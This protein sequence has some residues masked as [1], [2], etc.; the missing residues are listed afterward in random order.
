[1][2]SNINANNIDGTYP[3]AGVDNDSQGFRTNFTNIKNN[4]AYAKS[5]LEDLQTKAI[6]KSALTGS[7]LSND[8]AGAVLSNAEIKGFRETEVDLGT[9]SGTV[10]LDHSAGHFH[11]ITTNGSITL[12]FSNFPTTGKVG[13][14]RFKI[15]VASTAHT[16]TLPSAVGA[17][18]SAT[19][20][21]GIQGW[22][23]NIITF[24]ATGTYIYEFITDTQGTYIY[25]QDLTSSRT[26]ISGT[27]DSTSSTTG[28]F[29]VAGGIGIAGNT[30]IGGNL[31][32][33]GDIIP[34]IVWANV[35]TAGNTMAATNALILSA[36]GTIAAQKIYFPNSTLAKNGETITV[37]SNVA[38]T[39]L[40]LASNGAT[41][42]GNSTSMTANT[43]GRW[44]YVAGAN[45]WFKIA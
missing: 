29:T 17:G 11:K 6:L 36:S 21:V 15:T 37:A 13:R 38:I 2:A 9:A 10:T 22:S 30:Y 35:T 1:M 3:V 34:A 44:Q 16:M 27:T 41:I 25:I 7:S 42:N 8:L 31:I 12:A 14:V 19:S 26:A 40:T 24:P 28:A 39:A 20:I 18:D 5:E 32:V 43:P 4:L 23:S 33:T 45:S